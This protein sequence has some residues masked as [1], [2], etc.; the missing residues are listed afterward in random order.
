MKEYPCWTDWIIEMIPVSELSK[1]YIANQIR[2]HKN[3]IKES[4]YL[5]SLLNT[6]E[7]DI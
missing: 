5:I 1:W 6:Y 3:R 2:F 4:E 7:K